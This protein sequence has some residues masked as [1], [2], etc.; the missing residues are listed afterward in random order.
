MP[1]TIYGTDWCDDT[2]RTRAFLAAK[3][4]RP[5]FVD[6]DARPEA[7]RGLSIKGM[8][9]AIPIVIFDDGTR[10][11]EPTEADLEDAFGATGLTAAVRHRTK[12]NQSLRRF[13]QYRDDFLVASA[14]FESR[15]NSIVIVGLHHHGSHDASV[16]DE[17]VER[18]TSGLV[19]IVRQSG[20][21]VDIDLESEGPTEEPL[22]E[23][24]AISCPLTQQFTKLWSEGSDPVAASSLASAEGIGRLATIKALNALWEM[25]LTPEAMSL[26]FGESGADDLAAMFHVLGWVIEQNPTSTVSEFQSFDDATGISVKTEALSIAKRPRDTI[27]L[28]DRMGPG[29]HLRTIDEYRAREIAA[30]TIREVDG[31]L[32]IQD[33]STLRLSFGWIFLYQSAQYMDSGDYSTMISG[34]APLLVDRFTGAL[35][36]TGTAERPDAYAQNYL[37]S[38]NPLIPA[39]H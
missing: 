30:A 26:A 15:D 19:E 31:I 35:W 20:R 10:L 27:A 25:P 28:V 13:E 8:P 37:A 33:Q 3:G 6:I 9:L 23:P 1:I 14:D 21:T 4:V 7:M 2:R 17:N 39:L 34:N 16:E 32:R 24:S 12:L 5:K 11:D 36:I 29:L 18:L 22:P 38:G